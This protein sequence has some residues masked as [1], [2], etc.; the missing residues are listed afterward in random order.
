MGF[1]RL[2]ANRGKEHLVQAESVAGSACHGKM[3]AMGRIEAASKIC[4]TPS[5]IRLMEH[6]FMVSRAL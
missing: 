3:A 5:F 1:Q 6:G 4:D 2:C